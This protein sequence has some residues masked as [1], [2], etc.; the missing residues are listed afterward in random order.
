MNFR[1]SELQ[2]ALGH[3]KNVSCSQTFAAT[4]SK[5]TKSASL[6]SRLHP[7]PADPRAVNAYYCLTVIL[8]A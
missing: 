6:A 4:I 2:A 7:E 3:N 1:M 5:P 8:M